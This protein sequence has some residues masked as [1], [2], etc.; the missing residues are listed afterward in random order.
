MIYDTNVILKSLERHIKK[1]KPFS[2]I[3]LGDACNI[4]LGLMLRPIR[5]KKLMNLEGPEKKYY[6][7]IIRLRLGIPEGEL[8][9]ICRRLVKYCNQANYID[10]LYITKDLNHRRGAYEQRI[11][12]LWE[13]THNMIGIKNKNYSSP[14]L[15]HWSVV[16][17]ELNL[18]KIMKGRRVFFINNATPDIIKKFRN[19]CSK[20]D[21]VRT[22]PI[23]RKQ[24]HTGQ[25]EEIQET[26][27]KQVDNYDLFLIGAGILGKIYC[28]Y[29]KEMGG[30]AFDTGRVFKMWRGK[31]FLP[32]PIKG[33]L[34]ANKNNTLY[35][36]TRP[37]K[38]NYIKQIPTED[39]PG[40]R[41]K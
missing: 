22:Y 32:V 9:K 35:K 40:W 1:G 4:I 14:M 17:G 15:N 29:V 5:F 28:G 6:R 19:H 18:Y 10:N 39:W 2:N 11:Y 8:R 21:G 20:V 25:F 7:K 41:K 27:E 26:I 3:R 12:S 31:N 24:F 30:V 34:T 33:V 23:P 13:Q 36:R 37:K 16:E 38:S